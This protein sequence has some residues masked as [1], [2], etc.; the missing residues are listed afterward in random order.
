MSD[1]DRLPT[2]NT[3]RDDDESI[4]VDIAVRALGDMRNRAT[5]TTSSGNCEPEI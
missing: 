3:V 2:P 4:R 5:A 1:D